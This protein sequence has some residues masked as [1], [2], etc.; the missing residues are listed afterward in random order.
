METLLDSGVTIFGVD[1]QGVTGCGGVGFLAFRVIVQRR[2]R[3]FPKI[4]KKF[5]PGGFLTGEAADR[6]L[7]QREAQLDRETT[8]FAVQRPDVS[9][10]KFHGALCDCE[11]DTETAGVGTAGRIHAIEGLED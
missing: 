5:C 6:R 10:V 8:G 4:Q 3:T 11:P 7:P 9:F 2:T 1:S